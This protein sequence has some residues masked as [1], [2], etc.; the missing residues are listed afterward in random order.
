MCRT[1]ATNGRSRPRRKRDDSRTSSEAPEAIVVAGAGPRSKPENH[2]QPTS[3]NASSLSRKSES[4]STLS[5][6]DSSSPPTRT[7]DIES[8]GVRFTFTFRR[9]YLFGL[10]VIL[11]VLFWQYEKTTVPPGNQCPEPDSNDKRVEPSVEE[12]ELF[13]ELKAGKKKKFR[14]SNVRERSSPNACDVE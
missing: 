1:R 7:N 10:A 3:R 8:L 6:L 2:I 14:T 5:P 4:E 9:R 11:S 13:F 12:E